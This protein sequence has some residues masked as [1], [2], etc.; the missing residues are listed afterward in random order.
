MINYYAILYLVKNLLEFRI[1]VLA[2]AQRA[3]QMAIDGTVRAQRCD[4]EKTRH[5]GKLGLI[6]LM[7]DLSFVFLLACFSD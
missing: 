7:L 3:A 5:I 6:S 4:A 1:G 2:C